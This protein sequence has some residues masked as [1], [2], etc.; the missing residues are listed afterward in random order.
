MPPANEQ[1]MKPALPDLRHL[2]QPAAVIEVRVTPKA[3]A[4]RITLDE[5][6]IRVAV[7]A[8]PEDGRAN[9]AVAKLLAKAMGIAPSRLVLL[10]GETS[11]EKQFRVA[12]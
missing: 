5:G 3:S 6:R 11:R 2:A 9:V 1:G 4:N 7:T 8:V 12:P 10:R